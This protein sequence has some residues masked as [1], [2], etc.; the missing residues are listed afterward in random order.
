MNI[1]AALL[2]AISLSLAACGT[3]PQ[4][5]GSSG[6]T[7]A[8][9]YLA[10]DGPGKDVPANLD[11]IPDA[12]P[13]VEPLNRY[14]NRPYIALGKTY[15]PMTVVGNFR[16][17]GIASWYGKKFNGSRTSSGEIYDMYAMTAAH[18]TLPLPSYAR[19][20]NLANHKS[21]IVRINDRGPFMKDRIIDLSYTAAYKLGI[22]GDGSAEVEVDSIDPNVTVNS[23]PASTVQSQPLESHP[24][25]L[26]L[27][28]PAPAAASAV[29]AAPAAAVSAADIPASAPAATS[30]AIAPLASSDSAVYL[31][32]GAFKTQDAAEAY[33]AKVRSELG[34]IGKQLKLSTRDGLV[35]VHI[36]PYA[37]QSEAR[38]S[39]DRMEAKLGFKPMVNL[40]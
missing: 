10:G 20:T 36:G 18:P 21:V 25:N 22:I 37:S 29:A 30:P 33:L 7:G 39:A 9:G 19:V 14:A 24:I 8:G 23:I 15:T 40:P 28:P 27:V 17:Q 6:S 3:F 16:E 31:Q 34:D 38:S 4:R 13:K 1:K 12:V 5:N 32:L 11:S 26:A 2:I 35:R